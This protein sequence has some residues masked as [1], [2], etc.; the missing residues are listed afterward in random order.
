MKKIY[1]KIKV[2]ILNYETEDVM[3]A[4]SLDDNELP[5]IFINSDGGSL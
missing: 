2:E 3:S 4:S 5:P 1:E